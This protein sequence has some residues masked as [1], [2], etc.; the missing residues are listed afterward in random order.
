MRTVPAVTSWPPPA[1][2]TRASFLIVLA[3]L[4]L[5]LSRRRVAAECQCFTVDDYVTMPP[6]GQWQC[7]TER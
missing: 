7:V 3:D 1:S 6:I 2:G 4:D 5:V